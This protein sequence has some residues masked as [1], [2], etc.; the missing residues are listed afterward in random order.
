MSAA[1]G[2]GRVIRGAVLTFRDDPAI[3]GTRR[4]VRFHRRGAVAVAGDGRIAWRG[5][6]ARPAR[7]LSGPPRRRLR[8][9][10]RAA[11]L[12]RRPHPLPAVPNARRAR[13]GSARLAEPL[14]LSRGAPLCLGGAC[15]SR[16]RGVPRP[17][18]A[19]R[20]DR[21]GGL[22]VRASRRGRCALRRGAGAPSS[23][24]QRQD[25]DGPQCPG[26]SAGRSGFRA[27][28]TARRSSSAG[29]ARAGCATRSPCASRSPRPRRSSARPASL[30]PP[31]PTATCTVTSPRAKPRSPWCSSSFRGRRTTPTSMTTSASLAPA[32]SSRTGSISRE[33]ECAR[34]HEAGSLVVHC[35][36][37]NTFLGSGLFDGAHVGRPERPAGIGIGTDVGGG[38]SYSMLATLGEAYK[39]AMLRGRMP[40]AHDLF[41]LAT[42]GNAAHLGLDE[43][44][45]TIEAGRWADLVVL[46]P[47]AHPGAAGSACVVRAARRHP[48]RPCDPGRRPPPYGPPTSPDG[49]AWDAAAAARR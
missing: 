29:T 39:V 13:Q 6:A 37:A 31:I 2:S 23:H 3:V 14:H 41:H 20:D 47:A 34:L 15:T 19:A 42:R 12:H 5:P 48:L 36:T 45:G 32:A 40:T 43:E 16:G 22:L 7:A 46:D 33:R 10:A 1:A 8:R 38:T 27:R 26:G 21:R 25:D 28:G 9:G 24:R 17:A 11:G 30:P 44:I 18:G 35:P 4:A 49:L